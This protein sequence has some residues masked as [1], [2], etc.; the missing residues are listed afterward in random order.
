M[1]RH[2]CHT[3][4]ASVRA[5]DNSTRSQTERFCFSPL[6]EFEMSGT[7]GLVLVAKPRRRCKSVQDVQENISSENDLGAI[8]TRGG[9]IKDR[10][11]YESGPRSRPP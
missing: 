2:G 3:A 7:G 11:S 5:L 6:N 8:Y 1:C 10:I 9:L 4:E